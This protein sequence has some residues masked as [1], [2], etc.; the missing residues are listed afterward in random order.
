MTAFLLTFL[1]VALAMFAGREAVRVA[2]LAQGGVSLRSLLLA[3]AVAAVL[4]AALAAWLASG[5]ETLV[6]GT[7]RAWCVA[8][9]LALAALEVG[10]LTTTRVPQ[11][12]TAS[13]GATTLV[14]L[15]GM[16]TEASGLL[17][18]SIALATGE[19]ALAAAGGA[20]ASAGV[21]GFAAI[22]GEDWERMPRKILRWIVVLA[23]VVA[24]GVVALVAPAFG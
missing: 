24:A 9:A 4:A 18:L 19:G 17:V 7:A 12:P 2:Q 16:A 14:L 10:L 23:L 13:I 6:T 1:S 22:A 15:A 21:L 5:L 11:E 20:M 3:I 8:G